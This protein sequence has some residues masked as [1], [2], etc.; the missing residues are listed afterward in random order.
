MSIFNF[1]YATDLNHNFGKE[2]GLPWGRISSELAYFKSVT[3][4]HSVIMGWETFKSLKRKPLPNRDNYVLTPYIDKEN[5]KLE[6]E[7]PNFKFINMEDII[8]LKE[9]EDDKQYFVIGGA[10]TFAKV[11]KAIRVDNIYHTVFF[12]SQTT[13]DVK[14]RYPFTD[15]LEW[16]TMAWGPNTDRYHWVAHKSNNVLSPKRVIGERFHLDGS[17]THLLRRMGYTVVINSN[18]ISFFTPKIKENDIPTEKI[19]SIEFLRLEKDM[20]EQKYDELIYAFDIEDEED[21]K[22]LDELRAYVL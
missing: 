8:R 6:E 4:G 22:L 21:V 3:E 5:K 18:R 19:H 16:E 7:C 1:I 15:Y 2:G 9:N 10:K 17:V 14:Y 20:D 11:D 13:G 12:T